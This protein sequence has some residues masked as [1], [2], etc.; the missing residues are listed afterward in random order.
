V[1][2][3]IHGLSSQGNSIRSN[4][5][6]LRASAAAAAIMKRSKGELEI[7]AERVCRELL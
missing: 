3:K 5:S 4:A 6:K 1:V 2:I 7:I